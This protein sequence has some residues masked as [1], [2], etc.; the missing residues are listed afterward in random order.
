MEYL[1]QTYNYSCAYFI[2]KIGDNLALMTV[3]NS[4]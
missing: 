1:I 4:T 3:F 2:V